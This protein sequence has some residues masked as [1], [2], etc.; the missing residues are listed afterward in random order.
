MTKEELIY[1]INSLVRE[2]C[3]GWIIRDGLCD[4]EHIEREQKRLK[5]EGDI[6][7]DYIK[8]D[9]LMR[10][11]KGRILTPCQANSNNDNLSIIEDLLMEALVDLES[12]GLLMPDLEEAHRM[13][14]NLPEYIGFE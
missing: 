4:R 8:N 11:Q 9:C 6:I 2:A 3:Y 10:P 12:R 5:Q 13:V 1:K 14:Q 7:I